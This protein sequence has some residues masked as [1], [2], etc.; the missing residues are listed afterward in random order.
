MS[1]L[2]SLNNFIDDQRLVM[3]FYAGGAVLFFLGLAFVIYAD[4]SIPPSLQQEIFALLGTLIGGT[5]FII[6][7]SAQIFL[8][9]ARL[10][11]MGQR[12]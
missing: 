5:G 9:V 8:I 7:M 10:K 1:F 12:P 4:R 3:K 11:N 2:Q 6:A